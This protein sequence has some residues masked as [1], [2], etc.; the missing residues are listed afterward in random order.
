[1]KATTTMTIG[2][3]ISDRFSYLCG[4]SAEGDVLFEGKSIYAL[5]A[6]EM[7]AL[8]R[9]IQVIFQDPFSSLDPRM[10]VEQI[11]DE[12]FTIHG[13][14]PVFLVST[15]GA[16]AAVLAVPGGAASAP[17]ATAPSRISNAL[18]R[19]AAEVSPPRP[20]P[21]GPASFLSLAAELRLLPGLSPSCAAPS[22]AA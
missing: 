4:L 10:T 13:L 2:C 20:L 17:A 22:A 14:L 8:R 18:C 5:K 7:R 11:L 19:S 15:L 9:E 1:M 12:P 6:K 16:S 21:R 3:D